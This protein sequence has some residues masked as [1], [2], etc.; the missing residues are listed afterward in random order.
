M[1]IQHRTEP[2]FAAPAVNTTLPVYS[3]PAQYLHMLQP[4]MIE[5]RIVADP[6]L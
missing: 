1:I 6:S 5:D 2:K 3:T 4:E